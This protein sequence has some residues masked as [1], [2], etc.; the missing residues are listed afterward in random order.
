MPLDAYSMCPGGTGKKIKFCCG[1]FLGELQKIDRMLEGEQFVAALQQIDHLLAQKPHENR[2]CLLALKCQVLGVT[3]QYAAAAA[4]AEQFLAKHPN[5]QVA[6]AESA[7]A[8]APRDVQAGVQTLQR[9]IRVA[10]R[11]L[12]ARA[13]QAIGFVAAM[14]FERGFPV[15]ARGLVELQCNLVPEDERAQGLL[16]AISQAAEVPLL[17]REEP[18]P[19]SCPPTA[20][21]KERFEEALKPDELLDWVS[22]AD[23]LAVLAVEI[24]DAPAVW[25]NLA[26]FRA[27]LAENQKAVEA[28]RKF[29]ALR[30]AEPDGLED[31]VEAEATAMLL[32]DDPLGDCVDM[33]HIVWTVNDAQRAQEALLSSPR[34][35]A[36]NIDPSRFIDS[37]T[38]PPKGAFV[39][40]DRPALQSADGLRLDTMPRVLGHVVLFGRQTDREARLEMTAVGA[41]ELD[42]VQATIREAA[43]DSVDSAPTQQ[44]MGHQSSSSRLMRNAWLPPRDVSAEQLHALSI[45]SMRQG[46]LE[47]W[48][49]LG[50]GV[51]DGRTPREAAADASSRVR[52]LAAVM[53]LEHWAQRFP[54]PIDFNELR[55]RLGLPTLDAIDPRQQSPLGLPLVRLARITTEELSDEDLVSAYYRA[56]AF[57]IRPAVRKFAL[58][59]VER[60]ALAESGEQQHAYATLART[61]E[62]PA[63]AMEHIARGREQTE[64]K[65]Q[66]H[67][68]WDLME[69]SFSFAHRDGANA[70]RL[71]QHIQSRHAEEPGVSEA[72]TQMMIEVGLAH[73]DGTPVA[74]PEDVAGAAAPA[75]EPGGLWTPDSEQPAATGKLWTPE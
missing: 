66:S 64:A 40:L 72:L 48:P 59:I 13:Y 1:D 65:G 10:D 46:L 31:A 33:L 44:V 22:V 29:A 62:D 35:Q 7:I 58:A 9:A 15:A 60:P 37:Q 61:E 16:T 54:S 30:G 68:A 38:P 50:L 26:L 24:S 57:A 23:R 36:I 55:I 74:F 69:L 25:Q 21:W 49:D 4:T 27:R 11:K 2:E 56:S 43:G 18:A 47:R 67:A 14:L 17:L 53:V 8:V 63:R 51:L 75:A 3:K 32:G 20:S 28:W 34:C 70:V 19:L 71:L 45:E 42:A 73:P 41:D 39:L 52:V 12:S 6:L 5:N